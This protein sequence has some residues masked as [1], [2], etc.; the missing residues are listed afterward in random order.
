VT[1]IRNKRI[2][3]VICCTDIHTTIRLETS[4]HSLQ[5]WFTKIRSQRNADIVW[6]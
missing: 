4:L 2:I 5:C 6:V 3:I 1:E